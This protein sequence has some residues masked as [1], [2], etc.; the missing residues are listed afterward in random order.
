MADLVALALVGWCLVVDILHGA[1]LF[2]TLFWW[3]SLLLLYFLMRCKKCELSDVVGWMAGLT[4]LCAVHQIGYRCDWFSIPL[5]R[6]S[7]GYAATLVV[8]LPFVVC[9]TCDSLKEARHKI[10]FLGLLGVALTLVALY[11]T[12]SRTGW[13]AGLL[14]GVSVCL[15]VWSQRFSRKQTLLYGLCLFAV[16][17]MSL[18]GL[19]KMRPASADGRTLIYRVTSECI[20]D[21]P[22]VG[23]GTT[24]FWRDYMPRQADYLTQHPEDDAKKWADNAPYAFNEMLGF[25]LKYGW[26][27]VALLLASV[28][29]V[30]RY[31][32]A[33]TDRRERVLLLAVIMALVGMGLFS[34][35]TAYPY[36]VLFM[37]AIGGCLANKSPHFRQLC[38]K[39]RCV[40][41]GLIVVLC[42]V[43]ALFALKR[44][45]A[46][47]HWICGMKLIVAGETET[48]FL[49]Y[50]EAETVLSDRPH[51]LYNYAAELNLAGKISQSKA[52]LERCT[53]WL[54]DADTELM[55]GD[56]EIKLGNYALAEKHLK[57]SAE[58]IPSRFMPLYGLLLLYEE[59]GR[60]QEAIE[61]ARRILRMDVKIPSVEVA[62]IKAE[63]RNVLSRGIY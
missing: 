49:H 58:M 42:F 26:I 50:E 4:V 55:A 1:V 45:K 37:V 3:I 28:G 24:G 57:R 25:A 31:G 18:A 7:S 10:P 39:E 34:Y 48:A 53:K 52:V 11:L 54:N 40:L 36:I 13:F 33:F 38:T 8:G 5:F 22:L 43:G 60:E 23:H 61:M 2:S 32:M 21:A 9:R 20:A 30:V 51:F 6:N 15:Y 46:E 56:N 17:G 14:S 29:V 35:P 44:V 63:A 19:Y 47:Y 62:E 59:T 12:D 16:L 41:K 27:G